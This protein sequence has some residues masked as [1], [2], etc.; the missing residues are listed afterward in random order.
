MNESEF[1]CLYTKHAA[2]SEQMNER[3]NQ[4]PEAKTE[5]NTY[6]KKKTTK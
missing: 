5:T 1:S 4:R 3:T 6:M 2:N